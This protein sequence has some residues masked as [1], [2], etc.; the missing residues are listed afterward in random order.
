MRFDASLE[1]NTNQFCQEW[2]FNLNPSVVPGGALLPFTQTAGDTGRVDRIVSDGFDPTAP[3]DATI[4]QDAQ[5]VGGAGIYDLGFNFSNANDVH[6]VDGTDSL[7]FSIT[8]TGCTGT[9]SE[10]VFD[11]LATDQGNDPF[12]GAPGRSS[13]RAVA[14]RA[15]PDHRH[16]AAS[17]R[18]DRGRG[19][20]RRPVPALPEPA[21]LILLWSGLVGVAAFAWQRRRR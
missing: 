10:T 20:H 2:W 16:G 4:D 15:I 14:A 8:C 6:R 9:F 18:L 19:F 7:T 13:R 12:V 1:G 17:W 5:V 3:W 11:T 21:S